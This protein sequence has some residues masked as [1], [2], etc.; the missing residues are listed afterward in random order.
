MNISHSSSYN[1]TSIALNHLYSSLTLLTLLTGVMAFR[2]LLVADSHWFDEGLLHRFLSS[3]FYSIIGVHCFN[4]LTAIVVSDRLATVTKP[5]SVSN[6]TFVDFAINTANV[7]GTSVALVLFNEGFS[8][9]HSS[10]VQFCL[11]LASFALF[12]EV[13][14]LARAST[15]RKVRGRS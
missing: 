13:F 12:L 8:T 5:K 9:H 10:V 1:A 3:G 14:T 15:K 2:G 6:L 7:V 4:A 11:F